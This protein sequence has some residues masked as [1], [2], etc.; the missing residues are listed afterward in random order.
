MSDHPMAWADQ[1]ACKGED[2]TIFYPDLRTKLIGGGYSAAQRIAYSWPAD[3]MAAPRSICAGCPVF[4]ECHSW[5]LHH[6]REGIWAGTDPM[7]RH[8]L[9]KALGVALVEPVPTIE[10]E[11]VA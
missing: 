7:Q 6:E 2:Q 4:T 1:G 5:A 9:R 8:R 11:D 3:V 10:T